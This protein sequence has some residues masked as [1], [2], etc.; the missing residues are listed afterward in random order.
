MHTMHQA[1]GDR[2]VAAVRTGVHSAEMVS[3]GFRCVKAMGQN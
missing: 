3:A 1:E 2:V